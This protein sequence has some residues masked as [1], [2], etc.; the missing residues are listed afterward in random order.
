M[1]LALLPKQ[2]GTADHQGLTPVNDCC[3]K[4]TFRNLKFAHLTWFY[5]PWYNNRSGILII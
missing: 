5:L 1:A 4:F 2:P 3:E